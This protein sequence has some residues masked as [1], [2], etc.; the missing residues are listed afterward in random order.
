MRLA[1]ITLKK[2]LEE[3]DSSKHMINLSES[4][5]LSPKVKACTEVQK[6]LRVTTVAKRVVAKV[7]M[8]RNGKSE[9]YS[10]F[11]WKETIK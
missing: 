9:V 8:P 11:L 4:E 5:A 1:S 6:P 2:Y 10:P 3:E 7:R